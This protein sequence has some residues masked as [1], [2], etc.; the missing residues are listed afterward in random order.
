MTI[1][2]MI[3]L[4]Q[5]AKKHKESQITSIDENIAVLQ[6]AKDGKRIQER[7]RICRTCQSLPPWNDKSNPTWNFEDFD[8]RVKPEPRTFYAAEL[9][10]GVATYMRTD[11][12]EVV[13][14]GQLAGGCKRILTLVEVIE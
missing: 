12:D 11:R 2:E 14:Y 1:D 8:Y 9:E 13:A 5:D 3:A 4:F 10:S 7:S 6:A